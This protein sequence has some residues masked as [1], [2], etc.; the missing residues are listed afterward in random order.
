MMKKALI[1][2]LISF[3]FVVFYSCSH[4]PILPSQQVSYATDISPIILSSCG[5][6][7]CHDSTGNGDADPLYN[8]ETVLRRVTPGKPKQSRLYTS[9]TATSGEDMMPVAPNAPLTDR[10]IKLI[11]IWIAQGAKNN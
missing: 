7:G 10:Q 4:N 6:A 5:K 2:L 3:P 11:F 8:Y 1:F 9:I